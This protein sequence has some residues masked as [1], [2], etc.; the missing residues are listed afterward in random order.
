[1]PKTYTWNLIFPSLRGDVLV[2]K[3]QPVG[4]KNLEKAK[5]TPK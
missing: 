3:E 2:V 1:M 4:L 5:L